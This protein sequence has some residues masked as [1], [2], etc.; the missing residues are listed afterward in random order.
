M[1]EA[2][3]NPYL[4]GTLL[5][6]F[7][8]V[9]FGL[10]T[11]FIQRFGVG[12]H[13]FTTAALLY[14]GAALGTLPLPGRSRKPVAEP[15][16]RAAHLP[17]LIALA[18]IG[19][20]LAP[21]LFAWGLQRVPAT[22]GSLLLNGEAIITVALAALFYREPVGGRVL[23]ALAFMLAG[24]VIAVTGSSNLAA[25][26]LYGAL[27]ILGAVLCWALDNILTRPLADLDPSSVVRLKAL[28]GFLLTSTLALVSGETT[29][30]VAQAA[31]LLVCGAS[32]YGLSLRFYLMAQRRIGAGRTGSVFALAPF[33]GAGL[34][35]LLADQGANATTALAGL[36]F[37]VGVLLHLTERHQHEHSH[38]TLEH[39][40]SHHH[41]DEHHGHFHE[42][43]PEDAHSHRHRHEPSTHA[44]PHAPDVHHDHDH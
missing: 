38:K 8:A 22:Y 36:L 14:L 39:E 17:R 33:L 32:G 21:S 9:T 30:G 23:L 35:A 6:V 20:A 4:T 11:P 1:P 43:H 7:A 28:F 18:V 2:R 44:H 25:G 13:A 29:P 16:V 31:G 26:G 19:A 40:H 42:A 27:A 5:A 41:D 34:A 10:T 12:L 15:P 37:A 24:G 3:R